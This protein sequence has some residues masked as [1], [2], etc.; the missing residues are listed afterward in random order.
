MGRAVRVE[1]ATPEVAVAVAIEE[2]TLW[3]DRQKC[4]FTIVGKEAL[5]NNRFQ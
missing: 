2:E 1:E 3:A 5:P 4:N